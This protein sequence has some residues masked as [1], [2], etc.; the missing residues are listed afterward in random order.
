L[1]CTDISRITEDEKEEEEEEEAP[2]L[3]TL[4]RC[5]L[6]YCPVERTVRVPHFN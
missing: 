3:D 2:N 5:M 6:L 4:K 1:I